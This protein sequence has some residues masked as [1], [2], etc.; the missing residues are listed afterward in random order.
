M[1][2]LRFPLTEE[3]HVPFN[4]EEF[5]AGYYARLAGQP[6]SLSATAGWRA[7]WTDADSSLGSQDAPKT[8]WPGAGV[9]GLPPVR[10]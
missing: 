6:E 3:A 9:F 10:R 8:S 7:G 5:E 2:I 4:S 1:K